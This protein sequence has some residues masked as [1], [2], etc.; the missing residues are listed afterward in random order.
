MSETSPALKLY[1]PAE[2][3]LKFRVDPATVA[4]WAKAGK[5]TSIRTL[6][7][8]RRFSA[9]EVDALLAGPAEVQTEVTSS[10]APLT[11]DEVFESISVPSSLHYLTEEECRW[12]LTMLSGSVEVQTAKEIA[13]VLAMRSP[14]VAS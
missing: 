2:V 1:T 4:R 13:A 14:V 5:L 6:G 7:N 12:A 11:R 8:H 9:A 10:S 3:A